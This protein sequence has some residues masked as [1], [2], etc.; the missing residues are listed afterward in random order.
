MSKCLQGMEALKESI[1]GVDI[2]VLSETSPVILNG[3]CGLVR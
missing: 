3:A 2:G 1:G